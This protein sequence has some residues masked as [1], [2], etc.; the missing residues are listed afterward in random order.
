MISPPQQQ[1]EDAYAR[2]QALN[3]NLDLTRGKPSAEQLDLSDDLDGILKGDYHLDDGTDLRNYG[4][5]DGIPAAKKLG[6][7]LLEVPVE[8]V[9]VGGNSS[10]S[11]MYHYVLHA[12]HI[13]V[14]GP[15]SAWSKSKQGVAKVL[16]P[17]PGYDRHFTICEELGLEMIPVAMDENG[18]DM[19]EV[20]ALVKSDSAIKAMWCVPKYSNPSGCVYNDEVVERLAALGKIAGEHFRI[21]YDNAYAVHDLQEPPPQLANM[22]QACERQNS[23]DS[24][25]QF[26]STSK[27]TFAGAGLA[28]LASSLA[29]LATLKKHLVTVS[30]GPDKINQ[31]RH[32]MFMQ[33][34]GGLDKLMQKHAAI[35]KPKFDCVLDALDKG[36]GNRAMGNWTMPQGGYFVSFYTLPGLASEVVK[37]AAEAGVKL[38]PAG[39]AYPYGKDPEDRHIRL[40][41]TFP[42]IAELQQAM[43]V[44]IT[45][46]QLASSRQQA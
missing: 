34:Q 41:P 13:G 20:E 38:T 44:F 35:I 12:L 45:C 28:F 16:C 1:I 25:V 5:L 33:Q 15:E 17:V 2:L 29:N 21:L 32:V 36:L 31:Q 11:L 8:N 18:P 27:V 6:A 46:V 43:E 10:L 22:W 23:H 3:L 9:L 19:N 39:A 14:R 26:G 4:G 40:A 30:I 37:L 24:V 42:T 7:E